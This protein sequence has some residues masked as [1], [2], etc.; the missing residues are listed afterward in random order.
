[1]SSE[2]MKHLPALPVD[3]WGAIA[4]AALRVEG[5]DMRAWV[6]YSLVNSAWRAAL[7]GA[8]HRCLAPVAIRCF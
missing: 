2:G 8:L 7:Q 4:R 5:D 3:A 1:M 6:R